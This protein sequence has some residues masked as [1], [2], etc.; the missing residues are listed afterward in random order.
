MVAPDYRTGGFGGLR[1][2]G[3]VGG[4]GLG[5]AA[6]RDYNPASGGIPGVTSPITSILGNLGGL[7]G[8]QGSL[9][10]SNL[11]ALR[12]QYPG[13]YFSTLGTLLGNTQRR[14]AGDVS[15]LLPELQ[16]HSAESA[17]TGGFSGSGMENTKLLRDLGLTRYGVEQEALGSLEKIK[18]LTPTVTPFDVSGVINQQLESQR[19]ADVYAAA[20]S[21]EAAYQRALAA[22]GGAGGGGGGSP[23]GIIPARQGGGG[24]GGGTVDD[25]LRRYGGGIGGG[26]M[27]PI[28]GR[29]TG[30]KG[31]FDSSK[32]DDPFGDLGDLGDF[33]GDTTLTSGDGDTGYGDG[34][35]YGDYGGGDYYDE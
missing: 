3:G 14:A 7:A 33:G 4:V 1:S 9:T 32:T 17:V 16:Q 2:S 27:A 11:A 19:A 25:I 10:D 26:S 18:G 15:D 12:K 34:G 24:S 5:G 13:E 21:P 31:W 30:G 35:D 29:G 8:I 20:P 28:V 22:A 23:P 6:P